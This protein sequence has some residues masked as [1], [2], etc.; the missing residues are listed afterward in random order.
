MPGAQ[1]AP[2]VRRAQTSAVAAVLK[3]L[4]L[5]EIF[6]SFQHNEDPIG[7]IRV[8][9]FVLCS[10]HW[11]VGLE[12]V[13]AHSVKGLPGHEGLQKKRLGLRLR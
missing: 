1:R 13:K 12:R 7:K 11:V 9:S 6:R 5:R 3:L 8:L 2:G 4:E 10:S